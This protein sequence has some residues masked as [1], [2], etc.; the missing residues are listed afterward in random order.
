MMTHFKPTAPD[1][2]EIDSELSD[3]NE[4]LNKIV[5][6]LGI[7]F[8][9]RYAKLLVKATFSVNKT[10]IGIK[11]KMEIEERRWKSDNSD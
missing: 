10:R 8:G 2:N 3:I 4:R 1:F 5:E 9:E 6:K 11:E 7:K